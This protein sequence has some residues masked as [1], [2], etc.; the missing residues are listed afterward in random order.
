MSEAENPSNFAFVNQKNFANFPPRERAN[1]PISQPPEAQLPEASLTSTTPTCLLSR[2]EENLQSWQFEPVTSRVE[3]AETSLAALSASRTP[4]YALSEL[5]KLVAL[6]QQMR[7]ANSHL[8]QQVM[9]LEQALTNCQAE[10]RSHQQR[11]IASEEHLTQTTQ[12]LASAQAQV[13]CLSQKLVVVEENTQSE[14]TTIA[15][16]STQFEQSQ[17]RIAQIER[18]CALLQSNYNECLH[19]LL[20]SETNCKELR[21]RLIRQQHQT[22]QLKVALE[23]CIETPSYQADTDNSSFTGRQSGHRRA[24]DDAASPKV[25]P[26]QPWSA[27]ATTD[28]ELE[29]DWTEYAASPRS[30]QSASSEWSDEELN[31][32]LDEHLAA[33]IASDVTPFVETTYRQ[34]TPASVEL[35]KMTAT[36]VDNYS[37]TQDTSEAEAAEWEDLVDQLLETVAA[38]AVAT[39]KPVTNSDLPPHQ[40]SGDDGTHSS[41]VDSNWPSPV[42]YP[43]H[44]PKGRKSLAAIELPNFTRPRVRIEEQQV[45]TGAGKEEWRVAKSG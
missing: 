33:A 8:T 36:A 31:N 34:A 38:P 40:Q 3:V 41:P 28:D 4:F 32:Y 44:P 37:A 14:Q 29:L 6:I 20:Q 5:A 22:L 35:P 43:W 30:P 15:S 17:E 16:L 42:V 19:Q 26:I 7:A 12:A 39:A 9:Q 13:K 23:K 18:E 25:Q 21:T 10:S 11:A 1:Q 24:S 27:P 45:V 2:L